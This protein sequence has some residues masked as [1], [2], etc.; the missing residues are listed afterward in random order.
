MQ[1]ADKVG[2]EDIDGYANSAFPLCMQ[3]MHSALM[4][5]SHLYHEGRQ[6]YGL[7]LRAL[8]LELDQALLFWGRGFSKSVTP[9]Q[10]EKKYAYNIR[11]NYGAVGTKRTGY[12]P[13]SCTRIINGP[14]VAEGQVHGCPYKAGPESVRAGLAR[15]RLTE[16]AIDDIMS[17]VKDKDYQIACHKQFDYRF[18]GSNSNS[19]G[20]HPNAYAEAAVAYIKAQAAG[21]A[22]AGAGAGSGSATK[23]PAGFAAGTQPLV[24]TPGSVPA[25]SPASNSPFGA[26]AGAGAGAAAEAGAGASAGAGAGAS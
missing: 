20:N 7:F 23:G 2:A 25:G 1:L 16:K 15:M 4:A 5:N 14:A 3:N 8:G 22:G 12:S 13:A 6:Q 24:S 18:P 11:H 19:V 10:F 21:K 26:S 17:S 9:D